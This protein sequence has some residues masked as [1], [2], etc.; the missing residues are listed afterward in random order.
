MGNFNF[1]SW[2]ERIANRTDMTGMIT[3]LTKPTEEDLKSI[4]FKGE[5]ELNLNAVDN[6]IKILIDKKINGSTTQSGFIVGNTP[7]V[8]FQ[9]VPMYSLVQNV[10]YEQLKRKESNFM[11]VRYCGV[12]L[13]FGKFYVFGKG[14]RPVFY[15]QT[16]KAKNILPKEEHWRIVNLQLIPENPNIID[17][18]HER[19]WRYPKDFIFETN[20][21]HVILYD[22]YCWK[23][24]IE[25]CPPEIMKEIYGIT[26]L[27]SVL[28]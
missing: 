22:S 13:A 1:G 17:W 25:K 8:C 4:D 7:A 21:T 20:M 10:K 2:Q 14:G 15:E 27:K 24:F 19:E 28:M 11:K 5:R 12:G 23:Y 18:T 26:I 3:H 6:L 16:D 9:D